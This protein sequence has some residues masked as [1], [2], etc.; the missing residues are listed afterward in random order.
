MKK[1]LF[2]L[3]A[4]GFVIG[5][6]AQLRPHF[7]KGGNTN[8]TTLKTNKA[9]ENIVVGAQSANPIVTTKSVLSDYSTM[10]TSYDAQSNASVAQRVYRYPD[11]S[12]GATC[13]WSKTAAWADRGTGYNYYTPGGNGAGWGPQ[14]SARVETP[15]RTGWACYAPFGANGEIVISHNVTQNQPL[16]MST[17]TTKGTGSWTV[18]STITALGPP[19]GAFV[20]AWPRMMTNGT[21]HN[22]I[23]IIALTEPTANGGTVYQGLDGALLYNRSTDGG[24]TWTGWQILAGMTSS[25]YLG[26]GG[27]EYN[28]ANPKGDTIAFTTGGMWYDQFIMKSND[29]G[30]TWTKTMI[31][32]CPN[33]LWTGGSV[34]D[35]FYC[36][37][38]NCAA[39]IDKNGKVHVAFGRQRALG[40]AAGAKSYFP[41]TDGLIYWHE[42]MPELPQSLNV[43]SIF[44]GWVHD[45]MVFYQDPTTLA[46]Y[47]NS[48]SSQ[49]Q[50]VTDAYDN[51]FVVWAGVT[52]LKDATTPT[53]YM[54]RHLYGRA[55]T[56]L[57]VTWHDSMPDLNTDFFQYHFTEC[58]YPSASPT[59]T[60]SLYLL[61]QGDQYAGTYL[62]GSQPGQQGQNVIDSSYF[63]LIKPAK[64]DII[65]PGVGINEKKNQPSMSVSQN[66]PNPFKN[67]TTIE[68]ILS[69]PGTLSLNVYSL[70]G[71]KVQE[72]SM[73]TVTSGTYHF[74]L[75][76]AQFS[77]GIYFYTVKCNNES[78]THKMIVE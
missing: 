70:V 24:V 73:G 20:M 4:F 45:T 53:P 58:V 46:F 62:T 64:L 72:I 33:D 25:Q 49:A 10:E 67:Q 21:N 44:I 29:N 47:Q 55:S 6:F 56:N 71:Q 52:L 41:F 61:F 27:D 7:P 60:D 78:S 42:G 77:P 48:L 9:I 34:A 51:L 43:D 23:H 74:T 3:F 1:F 22:N 66:A 15:I 38:G 2:V 30:S 14:P 32:T 40:S 69:K 68:V 13:T 5:V 19:P 54:L 16:I 31:W 35:T 12:I 18:N 75:N 39:A 50:L 17:R 36:S 59:S 11:G 63:Y 28:W 65:M 57:G 26:F 8:I 37:D 76:S